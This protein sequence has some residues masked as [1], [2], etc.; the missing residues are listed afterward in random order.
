MLI[1]GSGKQGLHLPLFPDLP[2][3]EQFLDKRREAPIISIMSLNPKDRGNDAMTEISKGWVFVGP[4][5]WMVIAWRVYEQENGVGGI[6]LPPCCISNATM[7]AFC[8]DVL[9][10]GGIITTERGGDVIIRTALPAH[11]DRDLWLRKVVLACG[12]G[13]PQHTEGDD[14]DLPF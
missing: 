7:R 10:A 2:Y 5:G 3:S 11:W 8:D 13:S 6:C 1:P 12:L 14:D 4:K 9:R